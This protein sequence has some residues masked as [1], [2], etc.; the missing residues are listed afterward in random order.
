M[1]RISYIEIIKELNAGGTAKIYLGVD[2]HTGFLV[3]VKE[4]DAQLFKNPEIKQLFI[5]EAN[6]Y[7]YLDHPNIVKLENLLLLPN[8]DT[9]YLV[10]EYI[11]GKNLKEYINGVTGPLPFAN[12]AMFVCEALNAIDFA[13]NHGF[14]HNDIKPS[15]IMLTEKEP[16]EIKLID[17]GISI[18]TNQKQVLENMFTPYYASP[19]QTIPGHLVDKRTDIYSMGVTL[20]ELVVGRPPFS[21]KN[22]SRNE[23]IEKVRSEKVP[24]V[25]SA[26]IFNQ[27]YLELINEI[28]QKATQ[29]DPDYRYQNCKD[30]KSDLEQLL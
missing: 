20:Y 8:H 15:N 27:P 30:F 22:L 7:L 29:K 19:E 25:F 28:I 14:V 2:T 4:L 18:D 11:D 12:A 9:G 21:G 16:I 13:H 26:E 17:F 23:L 6:R 24:E 1:Q 3:A 5:S 10:M